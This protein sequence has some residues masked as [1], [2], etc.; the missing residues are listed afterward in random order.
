MT[1][2]ITDAA[3]LDAVVQEKLVA[4]RITTVEGLLARTCTPVQRFS[5]ARKL[6]ISLSRLAHCVV[7]AD[8]MRL[9]PITPEQAYLLE[10]SGVGSCQEL[11]YRL[12]ARLHTR[13]RA[14]NDEHH[15]LALAPSLAEVEAWIAQAAVLC[16]E[17][18]VLSV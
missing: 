11:Q 13:L 18:P 3:G 15:L 2:G 8:L 5:L 17:E 7:Q 14:T 9:H 4:A 10:L 1:H 6:G 12:P 16:A